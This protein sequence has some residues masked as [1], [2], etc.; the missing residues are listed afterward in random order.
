[1]LIRPEFAKIFTKFNL[2]LTAALLVL[3]L[4]AT[5]FLQRESFTR[6]ARLAAE[7]RAELLEL[8]ASDSD[9][10]EALL[11]EHNSRRERYESG[12]Y[13]GLSTS[14][15][16]PDAFEN[17][18]IDLEGYGDIRLFADVEEC[19]RAGEHYE[20]SLEKLLADTAQRARAAEKGTYIYKYYL[21]LL[22]V[23]DSL[24]RP[25]FAIAEVRGW[26]EIF[27]SRTPILFLTLAVS[28]L[29]VGIFTCDS[30]AG[31]KPIL[32]ISRRGER[33]VRRAKIL[34]ST[35][36]STALTLI[37]SL[38]PL[39]V[40][41]IS[42]GLS[43][44]EI[45]IQRLEEFTYCRFSLTAGGGFLLILLVRCVIF[46]IFGLLVA[47]VGEYT[48]GEL[49][50]ILTALVTAIFAL[51]TSAGKN[52]TILR[53]FS[54]LE[55]ARGNI[56]LERFRGINLAGNCVDYFAAVLAI[57]I[58]LLSALIFAA[59]FCPTRRAVRVRR[60][61]MMY[62]STNFGASIFAAENYKQLVCSGGIVIFAAML[63]L[64]ILLAWGAYSFEL[65]ADERVY[66]DYIARVSGEITAEKLEFIDS[67]ADYIRETL[68]AE[69]AMS[70]S[71]RSGELS[72]DDYSA[73][74]SRLAYAKWCERACERLVGRKEYILTIIDVYENAEFVCETGILEYLSPTPDLAALAVITVIC[75]ASFSLEFDSGFHRILRL[76]RRGRGRAFAAKLAHAILLAT[77]TILLFDAA[78]FAF[79][80]GNYGAAWLKIPAVSLPELAASA[81]DFS[82]GGYILA[83]RLI[84]LVGA[85]DCAMLLAAISVLVEGR[86][87]ALLTGA[88]ALTLP[89]AL[90]RLGIDS[91]RVLG[92]V[93]LTATGEPKLHISLLVCTLAATLAVLA[94][95]QKWCGILRRQK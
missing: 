9:D 87:S 11:A 40:S 22:E 60:L 86:L 94:A 58:L 43:S 27:A 13:A 24:E 31:M 45:P 15:S 64:K 41:A 10:Y 74:R 5:A 91:A 76:T 95:A 3:S 25:D 84:S 72:N 6:D 8:Y 4:A 29:S 17:V 18:H 49:A 75:A 19:I 48:D 28:A 85:V 39:A 38:V 78:E 88:A 66:R 44:P 21:N 42:T 52:D 93:S 14:S 35:V 59:L 82:I 46:S 53:L 65:S 51:L 36:I 63:A 30:R 73:Y 1:M 12:F 16:A 89:W 33:P 2:I 34:V 47:T 79:L 81:G 92:L 54:P 80:V 26:D 83:A 37:F 56:L 90:E 62:E 57:I 23:Y 70:E 32:H 68:A 61:K 55:L 69:T 50:G 20:N 67:E 7:A 71:Y 77:A